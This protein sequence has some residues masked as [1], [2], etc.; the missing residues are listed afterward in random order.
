MRTDETTNSPDTPTRHH[1]GPTL[2]RSAQPAS[3]HPNAATPPP[4]NPT[5][6]RHP[7]HPPP[8][9]NQAPPPPHPDITYI[10]SRHHLTNKPRLVEPDHSTPPATARLPPATTRATKGGATDLE[11]HA[12]VIS[13]TS[14]RRPGPPTSRTTPPCSAPPRTADRAHRP[15]GPRHRA[16]HDLEPQTGPTDLEDHAT[17]LSTTSNRGPAPRCPAA[18]T[19][20]TGQHQPSPDRAIFVEKPPRQRPDTP[21]AVRDLVARGAARAWIRPPLIT[22]VRRQKITRWPRLTA[23][24]PAR[25]PDTADLTSRTTHPSTRVAPRRPAQQ[26]VLAPQ[27]DL[28]RK[29]G[30]HRITNAARSPRTVSAHVHRTLPRSGRHRAAVHPEAVPSLVGTPQ[31]SRPPV[32]IREQP[33]PTRGSHHRYAI[34][35]RP[36][37]PGTRRPEPRKLPCH[38]RQ[39][40]T[41]GP[42]ST[43]APT[44]RQAVPRPARPVQQGQ[45]CEL[46][47]GGR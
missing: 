26:L 5:P 22:D 11:D 15:R 18:T 9:T 23:L 17:V 35:P 37:R 36:H 33:R 44:P 14:N 38:R 20:D 45:P 31:H 13:T 41:L 16:Q 2:A 3:T 7:R 43:S 47:H 27:A 28:P 34:P 21:A 10:T 25:R 19:T 1:N 32:R 30:D 29:L 39:R 40:R 4:P 12:T 24:N 42:R 46:T 6:H 8:T